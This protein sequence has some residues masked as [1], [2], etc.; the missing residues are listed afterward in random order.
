[1]YQHKDASYPFAIRTDNQNDFI[2]GRVMEFDK[3][4]FT[5][6]LS[7]ADHINGYNPNEPKKSYYERLIVD[8]YLD[9]IAENK[10]GKRG[11]SIK[12][13]SYIQKLGTTN[14]SDCIAV[15]Y[16]DWISCG[17]VM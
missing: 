8:A 9:D 16:N 14:L 11:T 12:C 10:N 4:L 17:E 1:M 2:I 15:P 13:I 3:N 5:K 7:H 6:K